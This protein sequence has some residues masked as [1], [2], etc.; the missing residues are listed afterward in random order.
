MPV[1]PIA[2]RLRIITTRDDGCLIK[3]DDQ[4]VLLVSATSGEVLDE[5][6]LDGMSALDLARWIDGHADW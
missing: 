5:A 3:L 1:E 2:V 6:R 4:H